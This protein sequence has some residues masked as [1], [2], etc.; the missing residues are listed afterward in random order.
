MTDNQTN[1]ASTFLIF[2]FAVVFLIVVLGALIAFLVDF[3][4]EL[5][6]LNK[7]IQCNGGA[8]RKYWVHRRRRLWL[9]LLPFVKY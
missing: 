7:E 8:E 4:R 9:S 6:Y 5:R 2:V 3:V 1:V